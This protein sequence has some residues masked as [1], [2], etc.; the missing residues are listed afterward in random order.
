MTVLYLLFACQTFFSAVMT[1]WLLF[2]W[3][4]LFVKIKAQWLRQIIQ[5]FVITCA[6]YAAFIPAN[7][8]WHRLADGQFG[9]SFLLGSFF[10]MN[11]L[12]VGTT[13]ALMGLQKLAAFERLPTDRKDRIRFCFIALLPM[14]LEIVLGPLMG[15]VGKELI[16]NLSF[17]LFLGCCS[18]IFQLF[19][20]NYNRSK[21]FAIQQ[22]ELQL[23]KLN[24]LKTQAELD[25]LHA[26]INPHFLYNSLSAMAGLALEDGRKTS[27]MAVE[28]SKLFRYGLNKEHQNVVTVSEE[29]D[30]LETY[31]RI[32]KIR[33][34]ER[35]EYQIHLE[36]AVEQ[37][38]IPKFLLQPLAENAIKHAFT[39]QN[40]TGTLRVRISKEA[41][42]LKIVV[43]DNGNPFPD[44]LYFGYGLK[45]VFD[46]L[47]LLFPNRH[48]IEILNEPKS[49]VITLH[50]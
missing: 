28:L 32:E 9:F 33:F 49:V 24:H 44:E 39:G 22:K 26:R 23:T 7:Y 38:M 5:V 21:D 40:Q 42:D 27:K 16:G 3:D 46:K 10:Y 8:G 37:V 45:S 13:L 41:D 14:C 30:M 6:F 43:A 2:R 19:Y 4:T 20:V 29:A 36:P 50:P 11:I 1:M 15:F 12:V 47:D 35:L 17:T 31:L 18:A 34:E 48:S 25:A